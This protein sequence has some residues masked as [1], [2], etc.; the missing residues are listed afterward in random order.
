MKRFVFLSLLLLL[1]LIPGCITA[2]PAVTPPVIIEFSSNPSTIDEGDTS[3]LLWNITG[4]TSVSI[5]QGIGQVN[6]AG[7]RV[8][9][10]ATSTVYTISATNSS[11]TVTRSAVTAVNSAPP[12]PAP[13]PFAVTSVIANTYPSTF[14]GA[15]P[16]TFTFYATITANGPGTV[17]YRWERSDGGYSD[18]QSITFYEAGTKTTTLQ[19]ELSGPASGWHRIHVLTPYDAASNPVYYTLNCAAGSLVTGIVVGVDQYPFTGPCPK[20]IHFWGIIA[21]NGPGTVT[22]RWERSDNTTAT[23]PESITF[24]AA[25]SQVVTNLWTR[26]EGTGWQRLHVLT[27]NDAVS[28][29]IDFVMT[30]F[31]L[32]Q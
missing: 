15:C 17:T 23:A 4:A 27:P 10:P 31:E 19:W 13:I 30:C 7:T 11:G 32:P 26:G 16:K 2:T 1:I 6:V 29:Q 14:T 18:I 22:Y 24:T 9:S 8:V 20:T 3:T 12:P 21:A 28:S 5:D 25:G